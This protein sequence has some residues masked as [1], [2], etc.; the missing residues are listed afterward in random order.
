M[1]RQLA[2]LACLL[3]ASTTAAAQTP[4]RP[5]ISPA[6]NEALVENV[7]PLQEQIRELEQS[8]ALLRD[9]HTALHERLSTA[10]AA[11]SRLQAELAGSQEAT[12]AVVSELSLLL[13]GGRLNARSSALIEW[14]YDEVAAHA[15]PSPRPRCPPCPAPPRTSRTPPPTRAA[16]ASGTRPPR[17]PRT[18]VR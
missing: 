18:G 13:T 9:A 10:E 15:P 2:P 4:A 16:S 11:E 1:I 8:E 6:E 17:R 14:V 7:A 3:A 12:A 5:C